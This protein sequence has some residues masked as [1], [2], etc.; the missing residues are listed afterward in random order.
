MRWRVKGELSDREGGKP[1]RK[2]SRKVKRRKF[3]LL[4]DMV[5]AIKGILISW[6]V[7]YIASRSGR[8]RRVC[9]SD[10]EV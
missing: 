4:D 1:W 3:D 2:R 8:V 10:I 7:F 9:I 6:L 5:N